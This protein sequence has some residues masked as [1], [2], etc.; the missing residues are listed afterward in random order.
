MSLVVMKLCTKYLA[1]CLSCAR[2]EQII[3]TEGTVKEAIKDLCDN[4]GWV[5]ARGDGHYDVVCPSCL[6]GRK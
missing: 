3:E 1:R 4:Y 2:S 6:K 5:I